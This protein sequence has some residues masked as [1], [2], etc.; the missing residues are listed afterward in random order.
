MVTPKTNNRTPTL[1][2]P[3]KEITF[4]FPIGEKFMTSGLFG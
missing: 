4:S 2:L 1:P 3:I